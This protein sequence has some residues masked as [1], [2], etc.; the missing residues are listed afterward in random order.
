MREEVA[1]STIVS[2]GDPDI[3]KTE[4]TSTGDAMTRWQ[5]K[6]RENVK[7]RKHVKKKQKKI[8]HLNYFVTTHDNTRKRVRSIT[9]KPNK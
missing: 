8:I 2:T 3:A 4:M 6:R 9:N 7:A 5:K 1:E